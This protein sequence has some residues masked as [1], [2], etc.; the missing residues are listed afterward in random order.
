MTVTTRLLIVSA[1]LVAT[2]AFLAGM[3]R[4]A[5]LPPR[6]PLDEFPL[7]LDAWRGRDEPRFDQSALRL[8]GVDDY[9]TRTYF[10]PGG[11]A[12]GLYVGY[13][14]RQEQGDVI[15]SPLN[16]LP[17]AGWQPLDQ[18]RTIIEVPSNPSGLAAIEVN[19]VV[20]G[21]GA[22]RLLVFYWYQS[23]NRVVASEY[24]GRLY[25]VLDALQYNRNDA[26]LVRVVVPF[27]RAEWHERSEARAVA[28]IRSIFPRLGTHVPV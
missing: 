25:S 3:S 22:E 17:G 2:W 18:G 12:L 24:W 1:C 13:Y 14:E 23:R 7:A 8:I 9:I 4:P 15:H 27:S 11:A 19:R 21:K 16:C 26:A 20:I 28:F 6:V 5:S 10:Q